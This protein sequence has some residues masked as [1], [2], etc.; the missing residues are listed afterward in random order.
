MRSDRWV[1]LLVLVGCSGEASPDKGSTGETDTSSFS[2]ESSETGDEVPETGDEDECPSP[3]G[4]PISCDGGA[5]VTGQ[6]TPATCAGALVEVV[7]YDP[8]TGEQR[9]SDNVDEDGTFH[10]VYGCGSYVVS[11]RGSACTC[12]ESAQWVDVDAGASITL[13][14]A[15]CCW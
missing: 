15:P 6:V 10:I 12:D 3:T 8:L 11:A 1:V 7:L 4:D 9:A 14:L 5:T 2:D 13:D